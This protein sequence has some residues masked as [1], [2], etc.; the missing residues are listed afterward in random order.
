MEG[1]APARRHKIKSHRFKSLSWQRDCHHNQLPNKDNLGPTTQLVFNIRGKKI[2]NKVVH[3]DGEAMSQ[4][5]AS[6][7]RGLIPSDES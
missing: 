6:P 1:E 7:K 2:L 4:K 3:Y 5:T